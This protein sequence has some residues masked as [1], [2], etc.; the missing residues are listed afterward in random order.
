MIAPFFV[1]QT[2]VIKVE[3]YEY[4]V[5]IPWGKI[6]IRVSVLGSTGDSLD[7]NIIV[8][9]YNEFKMFLPCPGI[10]SQPPLNHASSNA[11][12]KKS[13]PYPS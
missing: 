5:E 13:A 12:S 1:S 9:L 11:K 3:V 2:G 7:K 4:G 6:Y 10:I 8:F